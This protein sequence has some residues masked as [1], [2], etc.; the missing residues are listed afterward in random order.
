MKSFILRKMFEIGTR[1]VMKSQGISAITMETIIKYYP[2]NK[3]SEVERAYRRLHNKYDG[4]KILGGDIFI[5]FQ[6]DKAKKA[7]F[8][9]NKSLFMKMVCL[10][11]KNDLQPRNRQG[12]G[13][14]PA[15]DFVLFK[16]SEYKEE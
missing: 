6:K 1:L 9:N 15:D 5:I 14:N 13:K 12:E 4:V 16:E 7:D 10:A 2:E 3:A 8:E 11:A